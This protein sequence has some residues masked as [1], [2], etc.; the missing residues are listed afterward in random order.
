MPQRGSGDKSHHAGQVRH[1][2]PSPGE[3]QGGANNKGRK[4]QIELL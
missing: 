3:A 1:F 2:L 4:L